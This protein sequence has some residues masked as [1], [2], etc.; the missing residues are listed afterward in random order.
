MPL[1]P[2]PSSSPEGATERTF[3]RPF[4]AQRQGNSGMRSPPRA[5][6]PWLLAAAPSGLQTHI[7]WYPHI[8]HDSL[9]ARADAP[10][11]VVREAEPLHRLRL[12]QVPA[13]EDDRLAQ[14]PA[15]HLEVGP[16]KLLPLRHD[17]QPVR[18]LQR[19]VG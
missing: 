14:Q 18:P 1:Q 19:P 3:C 8:T 6:R 15:D 17:H 10:D 13:V 12:V 7:T 4:G 11:A 5:S 2:T 16:A 9:A